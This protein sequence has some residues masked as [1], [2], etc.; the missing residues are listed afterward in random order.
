MRHNLTAYDAQYVALEQALQ[1]KLLT[2][3]QRMAEAS[4]KARVAVLTIGR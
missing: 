1:G 2:T 3:D 4:V